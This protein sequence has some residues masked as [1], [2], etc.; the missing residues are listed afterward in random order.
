M[1]TLVIIA[2]LSGCLSLVA[3]SSQV[4]TPDNGRRAVPD[5]PATRLPEPVVSIAG[6]PRLGDSQA[7]I[8]IVEFSDYQCPFCRKFHLKT[9]PELTAQFIETGKVQY[10]Y[11]DFPLKMHR[12]S[13]PA[14][15]AA[16][17]A[18]QQ[19][20]YW[21]MQHGLFVQQ[22]RLGTALF[23]ELAQALKLDMPA[24]VNCMNDPGIQQAIYMDMVAGRQLGVRSTPTF[25]IGEIKGDR[26]VVKRMASG[27]PTVEDFAKELEPLLK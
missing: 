7:K 19:N 27:V 3:C 16:R 22:E 26:L 17:C 24:F 12:Q 15:I 11:K 21:A 4:V 23:S 25:L 14:A 20:Q 2:L 10:F 8:G 1:R 13:V 6:A 18:G 9:V 5:K